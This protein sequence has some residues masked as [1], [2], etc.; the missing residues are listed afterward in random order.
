MAQD[1]TYNTTTYHERGGD[2]YVAGSGGAFA[3]ESIGSL[4]VYSGAQ[5]TVESG[6]NLEL[7]GAD[8]AGLDMRKLLISEWGGPELIETGGVLATESVLPVSN[9]PANVRIVTIL[10]AVSASKASFW[11]TSVSAGREVLLRLVGDVSG[12]FTADNTSCAIIT[13]GCIILGSL[14]GA[15][16]SFTMHTSAA[17]DCGVLLRAVLDN[18][19]AIVAEYG[20]NLVES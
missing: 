4:A 7:A 17:S 18:T 3:V 11:L 19:W 13:S 2:R 9:L 16:A 6:T 12:T 14:G 1:E 8:L 5:M 15:I 20:N 10:A